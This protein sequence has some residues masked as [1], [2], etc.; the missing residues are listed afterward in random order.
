MAARARHDSTATVRIGEDG[1]VEDI[2]EEGHISLA[3][4][5]L[6]GMHDAGKS[7][8]SS[9]TLCPLANEENTFNINDLWVSAAIA[10]DTAVFDDDETGDDDDGNDTRETD[11]APPSHLNTPSRMSM[12]ADS[13]FRSDRPLLDVPEISRD[14][15]PKFRLAGRESFGSSSLPRNQA[16]QRVS[17]THAARRL[18]T[19]SATM[20]A[21]FANTGLQTPPAIAAAYEVDP[22]DAPV[23]PGLF[24]DRDARAGLS[25]IAEDTVKDH[26]PPV[27]AP[28]IS[29]EEEKQKGW[30]SLPKLIIMQVCRICGKCRLV[31]HLTHCSTLC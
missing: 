22:L 12:Q 21:I 25:A 6:L 16:L 11:S 23:S 29:E 5:L 17:G 4:R 8:D 20:P 14:H 31:T 18:S 1:A 13:P 9:L 7:S 27:G 26:H 28:V 15:S 19:A 24:R 10:A 30:K 2:E 3:R